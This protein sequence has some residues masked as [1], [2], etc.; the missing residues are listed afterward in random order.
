MPLRPKP[1]L[2]WTARPATQFSLS[3]SRPYSDAKATGANDRSKKLDA[4]P[5]DDVSDE[6]A[7]TAAIMGETGPDMSRGTPVEDVRKIA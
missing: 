4:K 7:K 2:S 1:Q 3:Q 6:A 5:E